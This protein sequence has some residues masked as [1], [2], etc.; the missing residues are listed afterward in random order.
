[1]TRL[2]SVCT[3]TGA[4]R[5]AAATVTLAASMSSSLAQTAPESTQAA[6]STLN[7]WIEAFN[8]GDSTARFFT[9]D[10][11]LVR[12]NGVFVGGSKIDDMEQRESK[13]GLRLALK[14]DRVEPLGAG[15]VWVLGQY[16]LTVPGKD[17]AALQS[18][19]GVAVHVLRREAD[20]WRTKVASFTRVQAPP[21]PRAALEQP[22]VPPHGQ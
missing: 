5:L 1:M 2:M 9:E 19:P 3:R 15:N 16:T 12:G 11:T 7:G 13:A 18:I 21:P 6:E 4:L 10:A 14:V 22:A 20:G 17:G 8:R